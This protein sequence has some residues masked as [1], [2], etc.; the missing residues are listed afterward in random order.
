MPIYEY[1]CVVCGVKFEEL[2]LSSKAAP[3]VCPE[4]GAEEPQRLFSVFASAG[5]C[6][7]SG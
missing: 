7:P 2:V 5:K 4:C 1:R 3:P 6:A